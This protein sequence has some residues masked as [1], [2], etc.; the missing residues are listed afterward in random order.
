MIGRDNL[1]MINCL[2]VNLN[3]NV[4]GCVTLFV[5]RLLNL[6]SSKKSCDS[7]LESLG[8]DLTYIFNELA[9]VGSKKQFCLSLY[10]SNEP[11]RRI[12]SQGKTVFLL[13]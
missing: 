4:P 3:K 8:I 13:F 7:S 12:Q 5:L 2:Y 11:Q 1:K 6:V 9:D 10:I